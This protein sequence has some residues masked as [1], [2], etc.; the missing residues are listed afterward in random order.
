MT[1]KKDTHTSTVDGGTLFCSRKILEAFAKYGNP[2][3]IN[4]WILHHVGLQQQQQRQQQHSRAPT[5]PG[6]DGEGGGQN[7][8]HLLF[9]TAS[10]CFMWVG[11]WVAGLAGRLRNSKQLTFASPFPK[12]PREPNNKPISFFFY[13]KTSNQLIFRLSRQPQP[14]SASPVVP[15]WGLSK[16]HVFGL[17]SITSG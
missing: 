14:P 6:Y 4:N 11:G 7:P 13:A 9:T 5:R 1:Q 15:Y 12:T 17:C 3:R 8:M 16:D 2:H 10:L